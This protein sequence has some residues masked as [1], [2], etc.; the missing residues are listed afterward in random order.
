MFYLSIMVKIN[1]SYNKYIYFNTKTIRHIL[2]PYF[3]LLKFR[4]LFE[5]SVA[6]FFSFLNLN[7]SYFTLLPNYKS[8]LGNKFFTERRKKI[9][10][11]SN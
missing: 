10:L 7:V 3:K 9:H 8:F 1:I 4:I 11:T 2:C 5:F 6:D